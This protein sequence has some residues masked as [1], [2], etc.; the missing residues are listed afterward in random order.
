MAGAVADT[1]MATVRL[2]HRVEHVV[3]TPAEQP[4]VAG[5]MSGFI[6]EHAPEMSSAEVRVE[7]ANAGVRSM[8]QHSVTTP[9]MTSDKFDAAVGEARS[10]ATGAVGVDV[11]VDSRS[12][13]S[14]CPARAACSAAATAADT[15]DATAADSS[16]ATRAAMAAIRMPN[17]ARCR[18]CLSWSI[19]S[20]RRR[21]C[22]SSTDV[23]APSRRAAQAD[24]RDMAGDRL[25]CGILCGFCMEESVGSEYQ[26]S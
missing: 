10:S 5:G 17:S 3:C 21:C 1:D 26:L 7:V 22:G 9:T 14:W 19:H 20:A 24:P 12:R 11:V 8:Q 16:E 15:S 13:C 2:G 25:R 23:N 4:L 18:A 6:A